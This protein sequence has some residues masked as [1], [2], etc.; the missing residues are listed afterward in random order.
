MNRPVFFAI[1]DLGFTICET[2]ALIPLLLQKGCPKGGV[3]ISRY[4][5]R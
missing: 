4:D 3:V 2:G 5:L 1:C